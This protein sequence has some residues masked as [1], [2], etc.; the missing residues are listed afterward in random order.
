MKYRGFCETHDASLMCL[1]PTGGRMFAQFCGGKAKTRRDS[2]RSIKGPAK[3]TAIWGRR[4][5]MSE[6]GHLTIQV[7]GRVQM[8]QARLA[9]SSPRDRILSSDQPPDC[10]AISRMR[11]VIISTKFF[12]WTTLGPVG[13]RDPGWSVSTHTIASPSLI[14]VMCVGLT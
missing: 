6:C 14:P 1:M 9:S 8:R 2:R 7:L 4:Y 11:F 5:E 10:S 12:L 3:T 13:S